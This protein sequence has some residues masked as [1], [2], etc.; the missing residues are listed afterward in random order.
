MA[1]F[2]Y[3]IHI[4]QDNSNVFDQ[5]HPPGN[6]APFAGIYRCVVCG[7]EIGIA[8]GHTLPPQ[9]H[10]QHPNGRGRVEWQLLVQA[11]SY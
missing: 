3:A 9:N 8:Q 10:H 1:S 5:K 4:H 6:F 7:K 2:K 11:H